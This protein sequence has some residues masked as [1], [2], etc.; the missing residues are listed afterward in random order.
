MKGNLMG[1]EYLDEES[2]SLLQSLIKK[3][4]IH[5]CKVNGTAIELLVIKGYVKGISCKTLSDVE[6]RYLLIEITQ[7]GKT[8]FEAKRQYEK[9]KKRLSKREWKIAII[10]VILGGI[11]GL[12]P[13]II[14]WIKLLLI[15]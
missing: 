2:E 14:R 3:N 9:E 7:K 6:P 5:N 4:T 13:T 8:Y 12:L 15:K 10:S 1:F 11:I